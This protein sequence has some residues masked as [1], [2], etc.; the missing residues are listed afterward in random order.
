MK[1]RHEHK[2]QRMKL[3][4]CICIAAVPFVSGCLSEGGV[5]GGN[6]KPIVS[7]TDIS[8]SVQDDSDPVLPH[9]IPWWVEE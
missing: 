7:P 9:F 2:G 6:G 3:I 8:D 5:S 4:P 1:T